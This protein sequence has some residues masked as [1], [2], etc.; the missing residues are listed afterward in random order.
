MNL[1][2]L[3]SKEKKDAKSLIVQVLSTEFPLTA[4]QIFNKICRQE[5]LA[6]LE[7]GLM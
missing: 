4:K 7:G 1:Q 3:L 2:P 5:P 6:K